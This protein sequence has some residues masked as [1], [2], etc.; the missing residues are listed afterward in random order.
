[1]KSLSD[2]QPCF[3]TFFAIHTISEIKDDFQ[4]VSQIPC[5][6]GHPVGSIKPLLD[7]G[8]LSIIKR[9][10]F[11]DSWKHWRRM[12]LDLISDETS[13]NRKPHVN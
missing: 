12:S 9:T 2:V 6:L 8:S 7:L 5:L 10:H 13:V 1:M 4:V 11:V 3:F